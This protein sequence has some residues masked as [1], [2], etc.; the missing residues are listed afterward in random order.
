[1]LID[2]STNLFEQL[3][4]M[5][6]LLDKKRYACKHQDKSPLLQISGAASVFANSDVSTEPNCRY[7]S[8]S[9]SSQFITKWNVTELVVFIENQAQIKVYHCKVQVKISRE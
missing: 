3:T 7:L 8:N 9:E 5:L 6:F 1:M 4:G 2:C